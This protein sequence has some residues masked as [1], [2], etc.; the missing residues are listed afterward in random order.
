MRVNQFITAAIVLA[1]LAVPAHAYVGYYNHPDIKQGR[2]V[3][4]AQD[5]IWI[6]AESGG[7]ASRISTQASPGQ[8]AKLSPDGKQVAFSARVNGNQDVYV[9]PATGG[10]PKRLTFHP[11]S[12]LI[13][14]WSADGSKIYFVSGR[15]HPHR[16]YHVYEVQTS[17]GLPRQVA[18]G[19]AS[20]A[21]FA[22][23]DD[24]VTFTVWPRERRTWKRYKGGTQQDLWAGRISKQDFTRL[25]GFQGTDAFPMI[26]GRRIY[27]VSDRSGRRNLFSM[28]RDGKDLKQHTRYTDYDIQ[29]PSMGEGK[30]VF[31][32]GAD[33]FL[34][35]IQ[36]DTSA[37]VAIE[38]PIDNTVALPVYPSPMP[39]ITD[40][41]LSPDGKTVLFGIRGNIYLV[42]VKE[43]RTKSIAMDSS[44]RF[45]Y[46]SWSEDGQSI[47]FFSDATGQEQLY[48]AAPND[49]AERK[50][51]TKDLTGWYYQPLWSPDNSKIIFS[52]ERLRLYVVDVNSGKKQL[53]DTS[54]K[55]EI[56][57]YTWS[58]DS[59]YV[60]YSKVEANEFSTVYIYSLT[61]GKSHAVTSGVTNDYNPAWD[62]EGKYIYFL[63]DRQFSPMI[64]NVDFE[65]IMTQMTRPYLVLL[66][67]EQKNPLLPKE[68]EEQEDFEMKGFPGMKGGMKGMKDMMAGKK[69]GKKE[70]VQ[71]TVDFADLAQRTFQI[72]VPAGNY[73]HLSAVEN[74]IFYLSRPDYRMNPDRAL[75]DRTPVG[76][77]LHTYDLSEK[78]H[79]EFLKGIHGY[80]ISANNQKLLYKKGPIFKVVSVQHGFGG[81]FGSDMGDMAQGAFMGDFMKKMQDGM[82]DLSN[83]NL[84]VV[85]AKEFR[86]IFEEAARLQKSLYWAD[87]MAGIDWDGVADSYRKLLPRIATRSELNQ[88]I[89]EMIA[90]LSTSHTYIWGG[91]IDYGRPVGVGLLGADFDTA[92]G[93]YRI[94]KMYAGDVFYRDSYS[95][96]LVHGDAI[97][98]GMYLLK[99]NGISLTADSNIHG[100]LENLAGKE[101]LLTL[102]PDTT[103][104]N[105]KEYKV[106]T[107]RSEYMLRYIDWVYA[108]RA[109]GKKQSGNRIGSVHIPNMSA[110]GLAEF[111]KYYYSQLNK[112]GLIIDDRFNGGGFVSQLIIERLHRVLLFYDKMRYGLP[113]TYPGRV[114]PGHLACLINAGAGSDGDIF[115]MAFKKL[116]LGK[117]IGTTTWGGVIGIR[118]DKPFV[119]GGIMTVPEYAYYDADTQ[120][121]WSVE[122][123]GVAPDIE[124]VMLPQD[125]VA[126]NDPQM[127]KAI[128]VLEQAIKENP[129]PKLDKMAP[130][131]DKSIDAW[132]QYWQ[133]REQSQTP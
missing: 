96:L 122:N 12:D 39:W 25:T 104:A 24:F 108:N 90:E 117:L 91:D 74:K 57:D 127:D 73:F 118:A 50:A 27:F 111:N 47:A 98:V 95:P 8:Q 86:Q 130:F 28:T 56:T 84:R 132:T 76:F 14:G 92:D 75:F 94:S 129:R 64:G 59:R 128:E 18:I 97:T 77:T 42:P 63:S 44:V 55:S 37:K 106:K 101:V 43:G 33:I 34:Y 113:Y 109:Y 3:F 66:T 58:P 116:K 41:Q 53:I 125:R 26:H 89:G 119:D 30:I 23:D 15:H 9:M 123:V 99:I 29:N 72:P 83:I 38:L 126:G 54:E 4:S 40:Y 60:A 48:T 7:M 10:M 102:S 46:P 20:R 81:M 115:P 31:Q 133:N 110:F 78:E 11:A 124:V 112:D 103:L 61:E 35:N 105:A 51:L 68:P 32:L 1:V 5:N 80:H 21:A 62:P 67:K 114:F 19:T 71:V 131:P 69:P 88:L 13:I 107:L 85:P 121:G 2:V 6:V 82:V 52:D 16:R 45:K 17:G 87:D 65:T 93:Y 79:K 70:P 22:D 120:E 49:N 100:L 36:A